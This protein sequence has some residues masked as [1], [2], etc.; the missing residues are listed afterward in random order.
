MSA[1]YWYWGIQGGPDFIVS[2]PEF[3]SV[4]KEDRSREDGDQNVPL[5]LITDKAD[6]DSSPYRVIAECWPPSENR[7]AGLGGL[8]MQARLLSPSR[9]L[10]L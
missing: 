2:L 10:P 5:L 7:G 6:G 4:E 1:F 9:P 8:A 3:E